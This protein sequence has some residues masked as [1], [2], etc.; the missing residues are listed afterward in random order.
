[1]KKRTLIAVIVSLA[2]IVIDQIIKIAIKTNLRLHETIEVFP[3]FKLSFVENEGMAYGMDFVGTLFLTVFRVVAISLFIF[4]LV[5]CVKQMKPIGFIICLAM[6]IAG[7]AGNVIDNC[8][9]GLI[10]T[11]STPFDVAHFTS[12]GSGSGAFLEGRVVDMFYFP[13]FTWPESIPIV[14]GRIFFSA[15]FN[16]ADAAISCGVIAML[17][18]YYKSLFAS[19]KKKQGSGEDIKEEKKDNN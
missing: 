16:F 10:F 6:I 4:L 14:G 9:Y 1:M 17:L 2:I 8:F 11:E 13:L 3:W 18:F 12:F 19:D 15:I 5:K 7:A